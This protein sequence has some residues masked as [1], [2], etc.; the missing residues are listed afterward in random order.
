M[1]KDRHGAGV[2]DMCDTGVGGVLLVLRIWR[3][4]AGLLLHGLLHGL[5]RLHEGGVLV[6]RREAGRRHTC[7]EVGAADGGL[8]NIGVPVGVGHDG[9]RDERDEPAE[10]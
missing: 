5:L 8:P 2:S 7:A 4:A 3:V 10:D 9:E 1:R 6:L